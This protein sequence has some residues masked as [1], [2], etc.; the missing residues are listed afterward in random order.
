MSKGRAAVVASRRRTATTDGGGGGTERPELWFK[1]PDAAT[2]AASPRKVW[3]HY[4]L[5]FPITKQGDP[6]KDVNNLK[7]ATTGK[8]IDLTDYFD[9]RW[10]PLGSTEGGVDNTLFGGLMRDTHFLRRAKRVEITSPTKS[11][12]ILTWQIQDKMYEVREAI[13][14]GF[15]G[16]TLDILQVPQS[17]T[18]MPR[19]WKHALE[20]F[21]AVAEV[22][23]Q[24]KTNFK[25]N[26]MPDGT[27]SATKNPTTL[28][29]AM[30]YLV[31]N[32]P[33]VVFFIDGFFCLSPFQAEGGAGGIGLS[34]LTALDFWTSVLNRLRT[35]HSISTYFWPC[36]QKNWPD[37]GQHGALKSL[38]Y[39]ASSWGDRAADD[40]DDEDVRNRRAYHHLRNNFNVSHK[41]MHPVAPTDIRYR[42]GR[43]WE[44]DHTRAFI[45]GWMAAIGNTTSKDVNGD[46]LN[47]V[48]DMVQVVTWSDFPENAHICPSRNHGWCWMDLSL[49][50]IIWYKTGVMPTITKD[51]LIIS[52]KLQ[53]TQDEPNTV[54]SYTGG[55]QTKF[56]ATREGTTT[57]KNTVGV[58]GFFKSASNTINI[59]V[60]GTIYSHAVG[61]GMQSVSSPIVPIGTGL[62]SANA[63]RGGVAVASI[64]SRSDWTVSISRPVEDYD[65]RMASSLRGHLVS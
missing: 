40:T 18:D 20:L 61:A 7:D 33:D 25:I 52:Y 1:V 8:S 49:F 58:L 57:S 28:A 36:Y 22:N 44:Q 12:L 46:L 47:R 11:S 53:P 55:K 50:F 21:N 26:C 5:E 10:L 19:L 45:N 13:K 3:T 2:L 62:V 17:A 60:G 41:W 48:A 37:A 31:D 30:K 64:D 15:D 34:G 35:T 23:R 42:E 54:V 27:T 24:D 56:L 63:T 9:H 39:G 6:T 51:C 59:N 32:F 14:A 43:W 29:D 38:C 65:L 16:F 4:F